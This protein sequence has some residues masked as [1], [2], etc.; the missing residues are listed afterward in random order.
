M[1]GRRR[2]IVADPQEPTETEHRVADTPAH[3][4]DH[5]IL[6]GAK[7]LAAWFIANAYPVKWEIEGFDATKSAVAM[8]HVELVYAFSKRDR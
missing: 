4:V 8:E 5:D 6:D 1:V 3:L 7:P 2:I